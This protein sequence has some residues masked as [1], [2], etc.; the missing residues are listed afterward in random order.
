MHKSE[1]H[2]QC[3][4]TCLAKGFSSSNAYLQATGRCEVKL[5]TLI[6]T[7]RW[8]P[9]H[10]LSVHKSFVFSFTTKCLSLHTQG[11]NGMFLSLLLLSAVLHKARPWRCRVCACHSCL[12][13]VAV[14]LG[15]V[16][17]FLPKP[18]CFDNWQHFTPFLD[19]CWFLGYH[20]FVMILKQSILFSERRGSRTNI[21]ISNGDVLLVLFQRCKADFT[22]NFLLEIEEWTGLF[23]KGWNAFYCNSTEKAGWSKIRYLE[24]RS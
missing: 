17:S 6:V 14:T 23:R 4:W 5:R 9:S 1:L 8:D 20:T 7:S 24:A 13:A 18:Q 2:Q 12:R 15:M 11:A 19:M 21:Y 22:F 10:F 16:I 3:G